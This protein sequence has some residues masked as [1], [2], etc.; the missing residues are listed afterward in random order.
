MTPPPSPPPPMHHH[1]LW[2]WRTI[3][4]A[5]L[6]TCTC[7]YVPSISAWHKR[8][9]MHGVS[10]LLMIPSPTAPI[11]VVTSRFA[12]PKDIAMVPPVV[13][14]PLLSIVHVVLESKVRSGVPDILLPILFPFRAFS[15]SYL[16]YTVT[17][18][19]S[20]ALSVHGTICD[21]SIPFFSSLQPIN[22]S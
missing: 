3:S 22:T 15:W 17:P 16:L 2:P 19:F 18:T 8:Q 13:R 14:R 5:L 1:V 10:R 11:Q 6:H 4:S 12:A 9:T 7:M 21:M 20:N